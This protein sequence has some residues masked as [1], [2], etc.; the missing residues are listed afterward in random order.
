MFWLF[1][2]GFLAAFRVKDIRKGG[3]FSSIHAK[4]IF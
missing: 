2:G 1:I 4:I 3:P